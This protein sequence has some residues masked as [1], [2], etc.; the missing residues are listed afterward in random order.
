MAKLSG[1]ST[2]GGRLAAVRGKRGLTQVQAS[3]AAGISQGYWSEL[4]SDRKDPPLSL[5]LRI[6][7]ALRVRPG[8][9]LPD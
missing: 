3:R 7:A 4:E 2:F 1:I 8:R 9:L 6:A 5:V